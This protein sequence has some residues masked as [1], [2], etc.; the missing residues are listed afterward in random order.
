M[1]GGWLTPR[2]LGFRNYSEH[3]FSSG[4]ADVFQR[5]EFAMLDQVLERRV[6]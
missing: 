2:Y 5:R 1:V 4:N 3:L 6:A